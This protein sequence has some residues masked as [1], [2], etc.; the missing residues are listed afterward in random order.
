MILT[1]MSRHFR[2]LA[3]FLVV[4]AIA[5]CSKN[6]DTK[7]A[8]LSRANDYF[9]AGRYDEAEKEYRD[10]LRLAPDDPAVLRQL[11]L[12]Y[13][14]QG[15]YPQAYQLLKKVAELAPD[16]FEVQLKFGL[17]LQALNQY[18]E[19]RAAALQVLDKQPGH[20]QALVLLANTALGLNDVDEMRK[21]I[22]GL[23]AKDQDRP[24]YHLALALLDLRQNDRASAES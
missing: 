4:V 10:V 20:E 17:T 1:I 7:E 14:T 13:Q 16:D 3:L 9:A 15:Q 5:A 6:Q 22:E 19:A 8:H 23:R 21:Y 18:K 24:G 12:L 11:G 2:M